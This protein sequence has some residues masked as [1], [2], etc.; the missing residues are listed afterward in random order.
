MTLTHNEDQIRARHEARVQQLREA[1]GSII[2]VPHELLARLHHLNAEDWRVFIAERDSKK[3]SETIVPALMD[4]SAVKPQI[5]GVTTSHRG[6]TPALS[7]PGLEM[8]AIEVAYACL[9]GTA[10][11]LNGRIDAR[12]TLAGLPDAETVRRRNRKEG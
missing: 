10:P 2:D 1:F 5:S 6:V 4:I 9:V 7:V 12:R 3:H 8:P 11:G